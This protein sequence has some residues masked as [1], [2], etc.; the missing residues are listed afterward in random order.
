[1]FTGFG[2]SGHGQ[3]LPP[4]YEVKKEPANLAQLPQV[5]LLRMRIQ[6]RGP[7]RMR[8]QSWSSAHAHLVTWPSAHAHTVTWS[9]AHAHTV[10]LSSAL[11]Q[12]QDNVVNSCFDCVHCACQQAYHAAF[13]FQLN[14][15]CKG[16]FHE[17][18]MCA[19]QLVPEDIWQNYLLRF[20]AEEGC[21]FQECEVEDTE[22][23]HCKDEGCET[24]FRYRSFFS[25]MRS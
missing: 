15:P 12:G 21:G 5:R 10:T 9:S 14:Q 25:R 19:V 2:L 6:S 22:H 23:F 1:M 16:Q 18:I 11:A 24:V 8:I 20:E 17:I 3:F 7:L 13:V 4:A